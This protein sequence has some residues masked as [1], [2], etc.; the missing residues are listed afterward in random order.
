MDKGL[1]VP[2]AKFV[3]A[4]NEANTPI[5]GDRTSAPIAR[6]FA[7]ELVPI[8][9][10]QVPGAMLEAAVRTAPEQDWDVVAGFAH[11]SP[12]HSDDERH[13]EAQRC[14]GDADQEHGGAH[15]ERDP[16]APGGA[17]GCL[18]RPADAIA[19]AI[20]HCRIAALINAARR[21]GLT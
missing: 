17:N 8:R 9:S 5:T 16:E 6:K 18:A 13:D 20:T 12:R 15:Q 14:N 10:R 3:N 1:T 11:P 2:A 4:S 21:L 19:A 7:P